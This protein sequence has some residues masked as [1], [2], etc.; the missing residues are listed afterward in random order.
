MRNRHVKEGV[1]ETYFVGALWGLI[2]LKDPRATDAVAD[3]LWEGLYFY[4][5]PRAQARGH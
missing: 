5:L 2:D 1:P 3:L 4:V